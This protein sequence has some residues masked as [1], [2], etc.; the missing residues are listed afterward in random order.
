[1]GATP[2]FPNTPKNFGAKFTSADGT[3][4]KALVTAGANGSIVEVMSI[5]SDDTANMFVCLQL[6]D[7][8][9]GYDLNE[10]SVPDGSGTNGTD[11]AVN[12][13]NIQDTP[14]FG[15]REDRSIYLASGWSLRAHMKSAVTAGKTVTVA[16]CYGDF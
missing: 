1:M 15:N 13:L 7:G 2:Q 11:K 3:T 9:V 16:G 8:S 6:Y 10:V 4:A 14:A 5:I 12:G